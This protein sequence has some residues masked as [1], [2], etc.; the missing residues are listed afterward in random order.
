MRPTDVTLRVNAF[1]LLLAMS[2]HVLWLHVHAMYK[3]T[4]W[5]Q[6]TILKCMQRQFSCCCRIL[7]GSCA[8]CTSWKRE[9]H[10]HAS[11]WHWHQRTCK[12]HDLPFVFKML[13]FETTLCLYISCQILQFCKPINFTE[14]LYSECVRLTSLTRCNSMH[15]AQPDSLAFCPFPFKVATDI[16]R[17]LQCR[18]SKCLKQTY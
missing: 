1:L 8:T 16:F 12:D 15:Y 18:A 11:S 2:G 4:S 5:L 13:P 10:I 6:I 9:P 7:G 14:V 3:L 17:N